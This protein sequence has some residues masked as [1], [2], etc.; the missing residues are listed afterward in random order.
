L[1]SPSFYAKLICM[2]SDDLARQLHDKETRGGTLS[3]AEQA[4]LDEWLGHQDRAEAKLLSANGNPAKVEEL[5]TQ[6]N[7]VL[8]Q[9]AASAHEAQRLSSENDTLRKEIATLHDR[10]A[11]KPMPSR[12]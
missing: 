4:H 3:P 9:V 12:A 11:T 7:K 8:E 1:T 5:R 2:I 6:V 10:L